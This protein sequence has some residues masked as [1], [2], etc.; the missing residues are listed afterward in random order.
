MGTCH[1]HQ[2]SEPA[3]SAITTWIYSRLSPCFKSSTSNNVLHLQVSPRQCMRFTQKV[4]CCLC[5]P[6]LLLV[7][8]FNSLKEKQKAE[9]SF[10][11]T[12]CLHRLSQGHVSA[13]PLPWAQLT[14]PTSHP[15]ADEPM[16]SSAKLSAELLAGSKQRKSKLAF[17]HHLSQTSGTPWIFMARVVSSAKG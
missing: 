17:A 1:L 16:Q 11:H 7:S 9:E 5:M 14:Q 15:G 8:I 3:Q 2:K 13:L 4:T 12:R 10:Y 6:S